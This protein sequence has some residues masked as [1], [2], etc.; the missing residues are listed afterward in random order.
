MKNLLLGCLAIGALTFSTFAQK[1]ISVSMTNPVASQTIE[2]GVAFDVDFTVTNSGT[3][4]L[5]STDSVY[6]WIT[7]AGSNVTSNN[8]FLVVRAN[9]TVAPAETFDYSFT[10]ITF[11][12]IPAGLAGT[13][14][15]C[16]EV[17]LYEGTNV[18]P[19]T[20][21]DMANN[22]SCA[23]T[24]FVEGT[25]DVES[26]FGFNTTAV[27]VSPNPATSTINVEVNGTDAESINIVNLS[28]QTVISSEI[29]SGVNTID[30]STLNSGIYLYTVYTSNGVVATEK[31]VIK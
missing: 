15:L 25:N 21:P 8:V 13:Q 1:D 30:V 26:I 5:T 11:P 6:F 24:N 2:A 14:D 17:F 22:L 10:G 18:T 19:T 4:D 16:V 23:S 29:N 28:G 20:E 9:A 7:V 3:V 12:S 31:L 27:K